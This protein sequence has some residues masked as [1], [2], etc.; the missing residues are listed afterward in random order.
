MGSAVWAAFDSA[1][2]RWGGLREVFDVRGAE[3][4]HVVLDRPH[5]DAEA[6][7][8]ALGEARLVL[9][10]AATV[11]LPPLRQQREALWRRID[12]VNGQAEAAEEEY[13][14]VDR[15]Y[16]SMLRAE[17]DSDAVD[18]LRWDRVGAAA[19]RTRAFDE[20]TLLSEDIERFR[21]LVEAEENL[22]ASRLRAI[23]GGD[24]V[25]GAWGTPVRV[26]QTSWGITDSPYPG[27]PLAAGTTRTLAEHLQATLSRSVLSRIRWLADADPAAVRKWVTAHPDFPSAVGLVDPARA[28]QLWATLA[29][30]S[31]SVRGAGGKPS[32]WVRGPLAQLFALAPLAI[33]NLNGI[34]AA[35][36]NAF[37]RQGLTH[38]LANDDL[39]DD[40]RTK[41]E[42]LE[43]VVK[44]DRDAALLSVFLDT[45]GAPRASVA[46]G[47]VDAADQITTLSHG[48]DTDLGALG[49]WTG[50]AKRVRNELGKQLVVDGAVASTAV[51]LF[52]EW[53]SGRPTTV[54]GIDRPDAGA[55]RFARLLEG[56]KQANP[57]AQR[58]AVVHS[59]GTT[60]AAQAIADH[61][62]LVDNAWFLGSAG[63][64][65]D[66]ADALAAQIG[67]GEIAVHAAHASTDW[68][69]PLGR[70]TNL[71]STHAIDPQTIRGVHP[72]GA[73]G[74]FVADF[75]AHGAV[76]EAV[77][78]HNAQ[79]SSNPI[80]WRVDDVVATPRGTTP[81]F[82]TESTGYL[83]KSA[84]S[85]M[86]LVVGLADAARWGKAA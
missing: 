61:P 9:E 55:S 32:R 84:E 46:W 17:P 29:A 3:G 62:T 58:N 20:V 36:R 40:A 83:D 24:Q 11:V 68:I 38:L 60:M 66:A 50:S 63:V 44:R 15:A 65:R 51:V 4:A 26:S 82:D 56:F 69:A 12:A 22:I 34:P 64:S 5:E 21:E 41:L 43:R 13:A 77:G 75:G 48:I 35:H 30:A 10:E 45:D 57:D 73:D 6:F 18:R 27:A 74:G 2:S 28:A 81:V 54:H 78:G 53:D 80:F 16:W 71:G 14:M 76:G 37:T 19:A 52:M 33:G 67:G 1:Y 79:R 85:F 7:A 49:D 42:E 31:N 86:H 70:S 47:D 23:T 8:T 39:T 59:L 25:R 72:V